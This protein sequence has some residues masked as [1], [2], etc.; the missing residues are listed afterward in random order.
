MS[1]TIE[2]TVR[3]VLEA[4]KFRTADEL[5]KMTTAQKRDTLITVLDKYSTQNAKHYQACTDDDLIG[6][7]AVLV[8]LREA[9][10]RDENAL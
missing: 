1:F 9:E 8:F 2:M 10:I 3:G 4:G 6:K 5:N 7:G